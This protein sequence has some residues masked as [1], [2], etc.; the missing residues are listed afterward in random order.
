MSQD[1]NEPFYLFL[2]EA[3]REG[4]TARLKTSGIRYVKKRL[5]SSLENWQTIFAYLRSENLKGVVGKISNHTLFV[6]SQES[7][8]DPTK[9][10]LNL[11]GKTKHILFVHQSFY[12]NLQ[13]EKAHSI[14]D[15]IVRDWYFAT[16][17]VPDE[18]RSF[19]E[20]QF[21]EHDIDVRAYRTNAELSVVAAEFIEE[22]NENLIF[23]LY[24]SKTRIW[25]NEA[26]RVMNLFRDYLTRVSGI[27]VRQKQYSTA[28]GTV[29]EIFAPD[30]TAPTDLPSQFQDFTTMMDTAVVDAAAAEKMLIGRS[31]PANVAEE[32]VNRYAKEARRLHVDLKHERE[33]KLL[34]VRHRM[35]SELSEVITSPSDWDAAVALADKMIPSITGLSSTLLSSGHSHSQTTIHSTTN[36]NPQFVGAVQGI[37][38]QTMNG[39]QVVSPESQK[40]L[41]YISTYA[42]TSANSLTSDLS[43]LEDESVS[44]DR[45]IT[46]KSRILSFLGSITPKIGS[47]ALSV[48]QAYL[49][50][51]LGL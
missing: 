16:G 25:A 21:A 14:E 3:D 15:D 10:L 28:A 24:V 42:G 38:A 17:S 40:I 1:A 11:I 2:G 7:Y 46:A 18:T 41:E 13:N 43:E 32:I 26:D 8:A 31:V 27:A 51:K 44:K 47:A 37:V 22:T 30:D 4:I 36:F 50:K 48:A 23:R 20:E 5:E 35:E 45:K 39:A 12:G 49:E 9:T 33:R 19:F 6:M 34:N 29:Y